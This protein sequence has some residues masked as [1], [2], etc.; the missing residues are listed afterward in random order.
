MEEDYN[1]AAEIENASNLF[2]T[3]IVWRTSETRVKRAYESETGEWKKIF[4]VFKDQQKENQKKLEQAHNEEMRAFEE[5]W[6]ASSNMIKYSKP[7]PN[8]IHLRKY[9]TSN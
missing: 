8:L 9:F 5:K 6:S 2:S 3:A 7:S 1:R 4:S